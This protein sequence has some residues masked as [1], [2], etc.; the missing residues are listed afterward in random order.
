MKVGKHLP[1][2]HFFSI[3]A[4]ASRAVIQGPIGWFLVNNYVAYT[5]LYE[6]NDYQKRT[7][8]NCVP[9]TI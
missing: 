3:M 9:T 6:V 4:T 5:F 2:L 8:L 1:K 7:G